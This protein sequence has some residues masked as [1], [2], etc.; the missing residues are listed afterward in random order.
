MNENEREYRILLLAQLITGMTLSI[1][2]V[3]LADHQAREIAVATIFSRNPI[4]YCC[5]YL[6]EDDAIK[7]SKMAKT[8][9]TMIQNTDVSLLRDGLYA[10]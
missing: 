7:V 2:D 10:D 3:I 1:V 9:W 8:L 6:I 5:H 4:F